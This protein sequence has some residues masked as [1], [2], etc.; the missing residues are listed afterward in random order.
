ML[1][2]IQQAT[3]ILILVKPKAR[4]RYPIVKYKISKPGNL[5]L[6]KARG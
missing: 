3:P 5:T 6:M 1:P 2:K 4:K